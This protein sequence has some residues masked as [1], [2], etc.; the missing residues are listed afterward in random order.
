MHRIRNSFML[1]AVVAVLP[2]PL[3][4]QQVIKASGTVLPSV[5]HINSQDMN[6]GEMDPA[7]AVLTDRVVNLLSTAVDAINGNAGSLDYRLNRNGQFSF[8]M[9]ASLGSTT[10]AATLEVV[11]WE[12][13][14]EMGTSPTTV[15]DPASTAGLDDYDTSGACTT[16]LSVDVSTETG[17]RLVRIYIGGTILATAFEVA[18]A[19]TFEGDITVTVVIP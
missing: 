9:P 16:G 14:L 4:G 2:L 7:A 18:P 1:L 13:G 11:D 5:R 3:Q 15:T 8:S 17:A 6:F 10:S 19:E 12:C